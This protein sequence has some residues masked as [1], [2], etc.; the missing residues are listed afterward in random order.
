MTASTEGKWNRFRTEVNPQAAP[1]PRVRSRT[2][3]PTARRH[4]HKLLLLKLLLLKLLLHEVRSRRRVQRDRRDGVARHA[5]HAA[6]RERP[7]R[8][9]RGVAREDDGVD[10]LGLRGL[11]VCGVRRTRDGGRS[12]REIA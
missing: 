2:V 7:R 8:R 3:R 9:R 4:L 12:E 6:R 11:D 10:R 1:P 5:S